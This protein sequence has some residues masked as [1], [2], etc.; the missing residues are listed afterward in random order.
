MEIENIEREAVEDILYKIGYFD[1]EF[2]YYSEFSNTIWYEGYIDTEYRIMIKM[3]DENT[4]EIWDC[5][6]YSD[7]YVRAG[8]AK[9]NIENNW[10]LVD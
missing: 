1:L 8:L 10:I 4:I 5:D 2:S 9:K 7:D 3:I 6:Y